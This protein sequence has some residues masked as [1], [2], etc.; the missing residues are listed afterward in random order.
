MSVAFHENSD[1]RLASGVPPGGATH[2]GDSLRLKAALDRIVYDSLRPVSL[3]AGLLFAILAFSHAI[4]L[5]KIEAVPMTIT[6]ALSAGAL[7]GFWYLLGR[8][9]LP[10]SLANA[11][12]AGVFGVAWLNA[13]LHLLL[14][15]EP[16]QST[17]FALL[18]IGAGCFFLGTGWFALCAGATVVSWVAAVCLAPASRDWVHF[19]FMLLAGSVLSLLVFTV[20]LRT[21][22]RLEEM[23]AQDESRQ[24]DLEEAMRDA[25][26]S[27]ER[28]RDLVENSGVLIGTHDTAG[29]VLTVNRAVLEFLRQPDPTE[30]IGRRVA[31][32]LPPEMLADFE[33]YLKTVLTLGRARGLMSVTTPKEKKIIEYDNSLRVDGLDRPIVRCIGRDVTQR[34][35]RE[36]EIKQLNQD[37]RRRA[38]ELE[39]ANRELASFAYSVS[40]DLRAPLRHIAAFARLLEESYGGAA[41][42]EAADWLSQIQDGARRMG[43]LVDDLL[44]FSGLGRR[45]LSRSRTDLNVLVKF[46]YEDLAVD[47][48]D[49]D[50]RWEL[51]DLPVLDCDSHLVRQVLTNLLSN[52]LKYSRNC[53]PAHIEIGCQS[54][55]GERAIFVRDNGVGFDPKYAGKLFGVFQ[56]LHRAEEFEGNGVGLAIVQR[57]VHKHGGRVWAESDPGHGA[58]F[59][60]T[61]SPPLDEQ[62][63]AAPGG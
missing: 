49:R 13:I 15:F 22:R 25:R 54:T 62:I 29:R 32:F 19:G 1:R 11:L 50:V 35:Q 36:R 56:R 43:S 40:H 8:R 26:M 61:L 51:R 16:R 21:F 58:T 42:P 18:I 24:L 28:Y 55:D 38:E 33:V 2:A 52:A 27:E 14:T 39:V 17:N 23:R 20:R 7:S 6:A 3:G 47:W 10:L 60:F 30:L 34:L 5:P 4:V 57:I 12:G 59:F 41:P 46:V 48:R 37:L 31:D 9:A 63:P 44:S 45:E 53:Q